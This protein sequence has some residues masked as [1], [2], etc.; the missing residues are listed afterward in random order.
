MLP[1]TPKAMM[2]PP[3]AAEVTV[4]PPAAA[5]VAVLWLCTK[6]DYFTSES[7]VSSQPLTGHQQWMQ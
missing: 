5:D 7:R 1:S 3:T 2:L 4:L 6:A